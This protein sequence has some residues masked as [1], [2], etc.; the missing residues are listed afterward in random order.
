MIDYSLNQVEKMDKEA[1]LQQVA[2]ITQALEEVTKGL[3]QYATVIQESGGKS[4]LESIG[5]VSQSHTDL[6]SGVRTLNR[7]SR[8]PVDMVFAQIEAVGLPII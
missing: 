8:G 1:A 2:A 6:V 7:A 5:Q 3:K 4:D